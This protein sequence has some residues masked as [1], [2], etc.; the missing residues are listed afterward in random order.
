MRRLLLASLLTAL[1]AGQAMA[2]SP[3]ALMTIQ[4]M[5]ANG[6]PTAIWTEDLAASGLVSINNGNLVMTQ[7]TQGQTIST[8][9]VDYWAWQ[10]GDGSWLWH[11]AQTVSGQTLTIDQQKAYTGQAADPWAAVAKLTS[12]SGHGDPDL[13]YGYFAKNNTGLTQAYTFTIGETIVPPV[14]SPAQVYADVGAS[15]TNPSGS[16]TIAPTGTNT[17]IQSF[18]LSA[19][20]GAT[21]SNAG[22]GVGPAYTTDTPNTSLYGVYSATA[23]APAGTWNYM[24]IVTQ[25][26]LTPDKDVASISGSASIAA[27]PEPESYAM[28]LAGLG[29]LGFVVAR[30]RK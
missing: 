30:A 17:A 16:I 3:V 6:Q 5:D 15:L 20:G 29:M 19:D 28:L 14:G 22:V 4:Q 27:V 7:G 23:D 1:G 2:G 12:V 13:S 18:M 10:S 24:Q 21:F 9:N 25:F 11:S 26:T 8:D